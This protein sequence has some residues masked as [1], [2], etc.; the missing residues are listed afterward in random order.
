M[1]RGVAAPVSWALAPFTTV[2]GKGTGGATPLNSPAPARPPGCGGRLG[3]ERE[4]GVESE[5]VEAWETDAV[6]PLVRL[7]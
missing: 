3:E 7:G 1:S 6:R 2:F 5:R 4:G